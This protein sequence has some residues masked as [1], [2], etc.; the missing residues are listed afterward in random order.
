MNFYRNRR[1]QSAHVNII[2]YYLASI[3]KPQLNDF[4]ATEANLIPLSIQW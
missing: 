1:Q 3:K 2:S 4:I